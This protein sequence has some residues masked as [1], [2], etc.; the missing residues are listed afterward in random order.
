MPMTKTIYLIT[1]KVNGKQ[2]VGQAVN[3]HRRFIQHMSRGNCLA[4]NYPVH[5]A[6]HKY[7]KEN[8]SFTILEKDVEN[9]DE[10]EKYWIE[11]LGTK[12]PNG[13]N[14][15]DGGAGTVGLKGELHP[16]NTLSDETVEKITE[17]LINSTLTQRAIAQK[18]HTTERVVNSITSGDCHTLPQYDYPLRDKGAHLSKVAHSE[19]V[20][21]LQNTNASYQS[22]ADYIGI[23]KTAIAQ[24]NRG[25]GHKLEGVMYPIREFGYRGIQTPV[26]QIINSLYKED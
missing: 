7:G 23:T 26:E 22:I 17:D 8:F 2:Y 20:W 15:V 16:R 12:V 25:E 10:K 18:Y 6:I 9:Y 14:I 11:K 13:Y 1:N 19:I 21:L 5:L 3:S 4:D 24:I